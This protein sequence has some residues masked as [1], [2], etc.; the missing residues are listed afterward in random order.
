M[1]PSAAKS[2]RGRVQLAH[3]TAGWCL[4]FVTKDLL[5][6][7]GCHLPKCRSVLASIDAMTGINFGMLT[8][9][10]RRFTSFLS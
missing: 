10:K 4:L 3:D 6:T 9:G 7:N 8:V 1:E 5:V 2:G